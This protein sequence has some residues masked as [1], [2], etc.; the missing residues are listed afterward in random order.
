MLRPSPWVAAIALATALLLAAACGDDNSTKSPADNAVTPGTGSTSAATSADGAK[1]TSTAPSPAA[2]GGIAD[3]QKASKD[4]KLADYRVTYETMITDAK[5]AAPSGTMTMAHKGTKSLIVIDG[6]VFDEDAKAGT[7]T[8]I[9]DGTSIFMCSTE[10][11]QK[12][13]LKSKSTGAA[14]NPLLGLATTFSAENLVS[15]FSKD[16]TSVKSVAGQTIAGR[17]AKCYEATGPTGKGTICL[18]SKNGM[19]L[20]ID[21]SDTKDG[22][23]TKTVFKAKEATDSPSDADFNPPYPVTS[24]PGQ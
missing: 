11:G 23:T 21:G 8:I 18:D 10:Q 17:S 22:K 19:L 4:L 16:G 12:T 20:L 1:G 9:D 14:L 5:G 24:I 13:C 3:L 7:I 2:A 15:R 6:A